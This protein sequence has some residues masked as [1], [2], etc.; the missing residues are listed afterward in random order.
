VEIFRTPDERFADLPEF[1]F[2]PSYQDI[3]VDGADLRMH[4]I[5]EGSGEAGLV[6]M[7]HGMPTWSYLYRRMI[8]HFAEAGYR[9]I[10]PDHIGFGRSDKVLEDSWYS[11]ERHSI[12]LRSLIE[13]LDLRQ[14]TLVCQDW[15]GPIGLR[16]VI[17]MP[18]RFE[19]LCILNTWLHHEEYEYTQAIRDW[20]ALWKPGGVMVGPQDDARAERQGCGLVMKMFLSF[21]P[22]GSV[23][24]LTA[25]QVYAAY[26][27][28]FPDQAS[29]AG[30]RRF[31][32]SLPIDGQNPDVARE[33][34]RCWDALWSWRKPTHFVWGTADDVFTEA[35]GREWAALFPQAT[36]D[37]LNAG[38]F[39]QETHGEEVA[40]LLLNRIGQEG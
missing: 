28:P 3:A 11:I 31:P 20:Q 1:P 5:D 35:W 30:P 17:D 15:G 23:T 12:A 6:L 32:L 4:F 26:E 38:H 25:E 2:E 40:T 18:D 29:K 9:C 39:L 37:A 10:A 27:A 33:G 19:R 7:L 22:R 36:F 16:Q 34:Q 21:F 13:S 14:I 24:P 8:P